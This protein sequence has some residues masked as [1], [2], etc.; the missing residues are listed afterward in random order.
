[1]SRPTRDMR[2]D[3]TNAHLMPTGVPNVQSRVARQQNRVTIDFSLPTDLLRSQSGG[4]EQL[5]ARR[6]LRHSIAD[7]S[8]AHA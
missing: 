6:I 5:G 3:S 4:G 7:R 1:M 8:D 2:R